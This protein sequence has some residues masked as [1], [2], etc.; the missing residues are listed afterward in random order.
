MAKKKN[1][2]LYRVLCA[3]LAVTLVSGAAVMS[4]IADIIGTSI[5]AEA[6]SSA[7]MYNLR[8]DY[9]GTYLDAG[10]G[11]VT[12]NSKTTR[13]TIYLNNSIDFGPSTDTYTTPSR[14]RVDDAQKNSNVYI[15]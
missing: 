3:A 14:V 10:T 8:N 7:G 5:V 11:I 9:V 12:A 13:T 1:E 2:W 4:P 6:L 15:I